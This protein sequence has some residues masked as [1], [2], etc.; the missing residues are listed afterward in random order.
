MR[1]RRSE[2]GLV[3]TIREDEAV[4]ELTRGVDRLIARSGEV[5]Y[6]AAIGVLFGVACDL[7][8]EAKEAA[9]KNE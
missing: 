5:S 6:A 4:R 1:K 2:R 8:R 3:G 9:E 7:V